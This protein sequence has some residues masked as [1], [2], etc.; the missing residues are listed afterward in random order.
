M[1]RRFLGNDDTYLIKENVTTIFSSHGAHT[2]GSSKLTL[3]N[4]VDFNWNVG[5]YRGQLIAIHIKENIIA[6]GF[7][8]RKYSFY[9]SNF[10]YFNCN[11]FY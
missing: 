4:F 11:V 5:Y 9:K 1:Y 8:K 6:Y 2:K 3:K 7:A 10:T